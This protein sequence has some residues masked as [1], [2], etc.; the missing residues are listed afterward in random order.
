MSSEED[1]ELE[2]TIIETQHNNEE[3][4]RKTTN[5]RRKASTSSRSSN[6]SETDKGSLIRQWLVGKEKEEIKKRKAESLEHQGNEPKKEKMNDKEDIKSINDLINYLK[7]KERKENLEKEEREKTEK[8]RW[9]KLNKDN[10]EAKKRLERVEEKINKELQKMKNDIEDL[11]NGKKHDREKIQKNESRI[12]EIEKSYSTM[13]VKLDEQNKERIANTEK[14][15]VQN[16]S[17]KKSEKEKNEKDLK[18]M[19]EEAEREK[20]KKNIVISGLEIQDKNELKEWIENKLGN[21]VTIRKI[22]KIKNIE[23][24][25]GAQV[26]SVEQKIEI[27]KNKSKLKNEREKVYINNDTTW[28]ERQSR[29]EVVRKLKEL[30]SQGK[31]GRM[32]HNKITTESEELYWNEK[33]EKWFRKSKPESNN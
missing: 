30:E 19:L 17:E 20:R 26:E 29:K 32:A 27:M 28:I 10:E 22:W 1:S 31:V 6:S 9:D 13:Q 21:Q 23:K 18:W 16:N 33:Y 14:V 3:E 7:N 4:K 25:I 12:D 24:T 5:R 2:K 11:K 15:Q 8:E